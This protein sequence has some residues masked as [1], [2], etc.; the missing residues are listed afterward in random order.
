MPPVKRRGRPPIDP[1]GTAT[2]VHLTLPARTYDVLF[3][4]A[5]AAAVT[6][7]EAIRRQLTISA[8]K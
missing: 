8:T 5:R 4:Q 1:A 3:R 7:P 2:R 6:V